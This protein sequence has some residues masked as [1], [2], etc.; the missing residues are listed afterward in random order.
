MNYTLLHKDIEVGDIPGHFYI[1]V[2][3]NKQIQW[4]NVQV[5]MSSARDRSRDRKNKHGMN[6]YTL[7]STLF[8]FLK[9]EFFIATQKSLNHL[10]TKTVKRPVTATYRRV[11]KNDGSESGV[12]HQLRFSFK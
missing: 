10:K 2:E 7:T 9:F 11:E 1:I 3:R 5:N 12:K 4:A 8:L 6:E